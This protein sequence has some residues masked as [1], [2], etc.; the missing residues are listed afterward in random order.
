MR[1]VK[2]LMNLHGRVALITGG[3]GH[4]GAA[5]GEA[6]AELGAGIVVLDL[7]GEACENTA[8]GLHV[9]YG[10]PSLPLVVDLADETR[11]RSVPRTVLS[12]LGRLDILVHCAGWVG[13]TQEPGWAVPFGQ[14]TVA[15]WD[16]AMRVNLTSAFILMQEAKQ[17]LA[18]SGHGSVILIASIYGRVGLDMRLY[19]GTSMANPAAYGVSKAGLLQLT[20]YLATVLAPQVRVNAISPGGVW[21]GQPEIF[22]ER[23]RQ[24]TPLGRMATEEDLKGA[25]AYLASDLS[26]YVTGQELV[27]DGGWTAW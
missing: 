15:A 17:A 22:H 16:A 23:Y 25:V 5:L 14:Q 6:L 1:S 26:A 7:A 13:T 8:T 18:E 3:A 12:K 2:D 11:L 24:R 10:V 20:R 19:E 21:R 27:V 9:E 4:I